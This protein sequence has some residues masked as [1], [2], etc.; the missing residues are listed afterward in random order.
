MTTVKVEITIFS[1]EKQV[2]AHSYIKGTVL[3]AHGALGK[4]LLFILTGAHKWDLSKLG[5]HRLT[6][7]P[8]WSPG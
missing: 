4:K 8:I 7:P 2:N 1:G 5:H 3:G 6:V